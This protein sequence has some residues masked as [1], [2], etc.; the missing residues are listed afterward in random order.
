MKIC[1]NSSHCQSSAC[2][3]GLRI[4]LLCLLQSEALGFNLV[5][6]WSAPSAGSS[7]FHVRSLV[8][9]GDFSQLKR[10]AHLTPMEHLPRTLCLSFLSHRISQVSNLCRLLPFSPSPAASVTLCSLAFFF[11]DSSFDLLLNEICLFLF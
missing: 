5:R 2:C 6:R 3:S 1:P 7:T 4:P 10:S 9:R 8:L 11:T